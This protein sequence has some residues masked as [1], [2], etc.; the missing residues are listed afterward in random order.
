MDISL[1]LQ[2]LKFMKRVT[3]IILTA[4]SVLALS[5]SVTTFADNSTDSDGFKVF[6]AQ[7]V[8]VPAAAATS[9]AVEA[10]AAAVSAE[11]VEAPAANAE[12]TQASST[13]TKVAEA[14]PKKPVVKKST[15]QKV[16]KKTKR[17]KRAVRKKRSTRTTRAKR[18][19]SLRKAKTYR[20][21]RGD[22]LFR[23]SVRS[24]VSLKRLSRLNKLYGKKKN[25][26]EVGQKLR[27]R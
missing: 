9:E 4:F 16:Q 14:P 17:T 27:L 8:E 13:E 25:H 1:Q 7:E 15:K 12:A 26:I 5:F 23:I 19:Q 21:R 20:V 22:T 2:G 6:G 11:V 3:P 18:N 24:G 10:P